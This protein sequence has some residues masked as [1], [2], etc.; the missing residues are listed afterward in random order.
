[1]LFT[2]IAA[3]S[4]LPRLGT[5]I[6]G[7]DQDVYINPWADMWTLRALQDPARSL[8]YTDFL[9]FP[10]GASL[11]YH[12]FSHFTSAISLLLRP[13]F[14]PLAA[15]N[16]T[17]LLHLVLAG[18]SM[19]HL[20]RYLTG[21][22]LAALMAGI[23]FAFNSHNIW[24]TAHPVLVSIWPLPW[25]A[26]FLLQAIER[27]TPSRAVLA[28]FFVFLA[29]LNSTLMLILTGLWLIFIVFY[30]LGSRRLN[31]TSFSTLVLFAA[32]SLALVVIPLYPLLRESLLQ[33]NTSFIVDE[34]PSVPA[35]LMAPVTPYWSD[36]F[37]RS[38]HFG[39]I[40]FLLVLAAML[41]PR[42]SWAWLLGLVAIYLFAI[43]PQPVASGDPLDITLPWSEV[44]RPLL[45]H[46]HRL[47]VLLSALLA[48]LVAFGW[49]TVAARLA[50]ARRPRLILAALLS[51]LIFAEYTAPGFPY[52][53]PR[54]SP[55]YTDYLQSVSDD[56][57]LAIL[58]TG[59]Q[60]DKL[61][62]YYQTLHGHRM[63]G[64]VIS[65]PQQETFQFIEANPILRAGAINWTPTSLPPDLEPSLAE[66][67]RHGIG[68]LVLEKSLFERHDLD[69][70]AWRAAIPRTPVYEDEQVVAYST[71][72]E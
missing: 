14:G 33:A 22:T 26:L 28:A 72:P 51:I 5:I 2:A 52:T 63:T 54:V 30:A 6:A 49:C 34:G 53:I 59:R 42:Q 61:Y 38:L 12:S 50:A 1:M 66:L 32:L 25:A 36:Q 9:F 18:W 40:P 3:W 56:I 62:M 45:R 19:F 44:I 68:I 13:L 43:G 64:G 21:S 55:F 70:S 47:N 16:L 15:Y 24:Q 67:S 37:P 48:V 20:A 71:M 8:W 31:R 7:S 58:P 10:Q 29:A 46:S 23:V 11:H 69:L 39:V 60:Q 65:R 17:I 27:A 57:A 41:R 4:I 35:D